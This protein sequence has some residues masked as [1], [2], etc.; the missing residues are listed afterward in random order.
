MGYLCISN[1]RNESEIQFQCVTAC[2]SITFP[3][4]IFGIGKIQHPSNNKKTAFVNKYT[5]HISLTNPNK[6]T[7]KRQTDINIHYVGASAHTLTHTHTGVTYHK[8]CESSG[9]AR[10]HVNCTYACSVCLNAVNVRAFGTGLFLRCAPP[11][12]A[13]NLFPSDERAGRA[14]DSQISGLIV[15]G[16]RA[17]TSE[18]VTMSRC[19]RYSN[20]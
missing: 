14:F 5:Y 8:L 18:H 19:I 16:L 1:A 3:I 13:E 6:Q 11:A 4:S 10:I 15:F 17:Y 20:K 2:N 9:S 12:C 7:R